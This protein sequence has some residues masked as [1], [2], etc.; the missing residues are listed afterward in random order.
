MTE[1]NVKP[2]LP[3]LVA[4]T[5]GIVP[6]NFEDCY[7]LGQLL[8]KSGMVPKDYAGN[9]EACTV[10]IMQ[11]LEVGMSPMAAIQSI[12]V[13]NGRPNLW[14]DGM[15]AVV[16]A[17]GQL[18]WKKEED[19]GATATCT[20]K[21]R[22]KADPIS[23]KFSIEDSKKAG[24]L[25]KS[26]PWSSYPQRMRQMRARAW[27]LRDEFSDVLKGFGSAEE[28]QDIP[29]R[30]VTPKASIEVPPIPPV[31]QDAE[32]VPEK[33]AKTEQ[34]TFLQELETDL[35][36]ATDAETLTEVWIHNEDRINELRV[37]ADAQVLYD[38]REKQLSDLEG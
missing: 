2:L 4:G 38:I 11:G 34:E 12:A 17:S 7:R 21:R 35:A 15:L 33:P 25:G 28:A 23:R 10:A 26:G 32:V 6:Q 30:D 36:C 13:I 27:A 22:G 20:V 18:E 5:R 29:M 16:E 31:V 9:P 8:A 1:S 19:D 14:G 3:S 37:G 24:L